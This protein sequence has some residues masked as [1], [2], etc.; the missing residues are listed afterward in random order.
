MLAFYAL[1]G[2]A[3]DDP[4]NSKRFWTPTESGDKYRVYEQ[5]I[6]AKLIDLSLEHY[7]N[8]VITSTLGIRKLTIS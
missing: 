4:S 1:D 3:P 5:Q 7:S 2:A 8:V 6:S